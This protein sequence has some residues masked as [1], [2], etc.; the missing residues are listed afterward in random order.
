M[1]Y[2]D[3]NEI[4]A[5]FFQNRHKPVHI[6]LGTDWWT[7]CDDV[8][9]LRLIAWAVQND[10]CIL[11]AVGINGCMEFSAP[12]VDAF[13]TAEGCPDIAIGIDREATDFG[14]NP[15]YQRRMTEYPH[16]IQSNDECEDAVKLYRRILAS[17]EDRLDIIEIGYPQILSGLLQSTG[18]DVSDRSG[19]ELV[20]EK[21]NKLWMMAGNW[22]NLDSG[23]ENN[24]TRNDRS[25]KAGSYVCEYWP[26]PI[27]FLGW[28]VSSHVLTGGILTSENDMVHMAFCDHGSQN[29]RSS[30]DP[31]LVWM[32]LCGDEETAGYETLRGKASVNAETGE[33]SFALH[34]AGSHCF[35]KKAKPDD[36]YQNSINAI[37]EEKQCF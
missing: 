16:S 22:E 9:A 23:R 6:L 19:Y 33:N 12:S 25:R 20:K 27:T 13:L 34:A 35:V 14:G 30:W 29:G 32:A 4:K 3:I 31:M 10:Y 26:T 21:V 11:D 37:L 28:E 8:A 5:R 1:I 7:D 36:F 24:F 15:P 18:D 2:L 17:C